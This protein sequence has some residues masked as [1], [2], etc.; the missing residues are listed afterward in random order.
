MAN[1]IPIVLRVNGE[2]HSL[3][4]PPNKMLLKVLREDLGLRGTKSNCGEGEC[5]ACTVLL[6]GEAI[7]SCLLLAV[8]AQ[9]K[10]ITTIEG[11]GD[12][13]HL[14]PVQEAFVEAGSIQCGYCTPG[15]IMSTVALLEEEPTPSHEAMESAFAGNICRCTGYVKIEQAV[16]AASGQGGKEA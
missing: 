8:R 13:E 3:Q 15:F 11:I 12:A 6:D 4:V 14:H 9:N 16:L 5:G 1:T 10:E 7:N 2:T